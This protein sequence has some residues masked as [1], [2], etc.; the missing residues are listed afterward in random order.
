MSLLVSDLDA[1]ATGVTDAIARH[2]RMVAE[3]SA[4]AETQIR[5]A[6]AALTARAADLAAAAGEASDAA[7]VAGEDLGRQVIRLETAGQGVGDQVRAIEE[8]LTEQR[9][10]LI[11]VSHDLRANHEAFSAQ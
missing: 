8:S 5:E 9:T 4:L 11:N 10:A 3:A 7:R 2:A 1:Q 6:E